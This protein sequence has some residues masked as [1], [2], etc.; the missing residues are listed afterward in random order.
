M[1][2]QLDNFIKSNI[3]TYSD[4]KLFFVIIC[5]VEERKKDIFKLLALK[6]AKRIC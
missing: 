2:D 1:K 6:K 3:F 4:I 5:S